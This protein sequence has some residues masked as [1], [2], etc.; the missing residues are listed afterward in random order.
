MD[1]ASLNKTK[2]SAGSRKSSEIALDQEE[3]FGVCL[4]EP[5][6]VLD[7]FLKSVEQG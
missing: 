4:I 6:G 1:L 3:I 7:C 2:A 5:G